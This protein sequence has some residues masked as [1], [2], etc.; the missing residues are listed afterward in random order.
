MTEKITMTV[1]DLLA[2][3]YEEMRL[4]ESLELMK[5]S[6][7]E[8]IQALLDKQ[9]QIRRTRSRWLDEQVDALI[10]VGDYTAESDL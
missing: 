4:A 7:P 2:W 8:E 1:G 10:G 6:L 3:A 9:I 5:D